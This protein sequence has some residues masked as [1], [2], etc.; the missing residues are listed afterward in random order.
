MV[1]CASCFVSLLVL[2][3]IVF[4]CC[5]F[6]WYVVVLGYVLLRIAVAVNSVVV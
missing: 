1:G 3:V 2:L 6:V 5:G 4:V